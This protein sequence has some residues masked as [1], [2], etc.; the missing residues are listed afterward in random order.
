MSQ[1][2][3]KKTRKEIK[4]MFDSMLDTV[5]QEPF[6]QRLRLAWSIL[7]KKN[8]FIIKAKRNNQ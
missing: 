1:S 4:R 5:G 6:G 3:V 2:R 8:Y 7:W